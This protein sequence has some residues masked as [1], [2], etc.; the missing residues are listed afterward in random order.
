M[1]KTFQERSAAVVDLWW[2][3]LGD[4]FPLLLGAAFV[5]ASVVALAARTEPDGKARARL[6]YLLVLIALGVGG[7]LAV[8]RAS[9]F[10]DAYISFRYARNF[11]EG[12]GLVW[13][14]GERVEGYTNFLWTLGL[15]LG[16][17][18]TGLPAEVLGLWGCLAVL[19]AN[20]L[21]VWRIGRALVGPRHIPLAPLLLGAHA[22]LRL[23]RHHGHGDGRLLAGREPRALGA[24][25]PG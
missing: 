24:R 22:R 16:I 7:W 8:S 11:A 12:N 6:G 21:V 17:R 25:G 20:L 19:A 13:N 3:G 2:T 1:L 9:L 14:L 10:D 18:L 15:G 5:G 23:L 4:A